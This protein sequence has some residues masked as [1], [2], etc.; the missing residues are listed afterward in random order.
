MYI[1]SACIFIPRLKSG[2]T[3]AIFFR[4]YSSAERQ[5]TNISDRFCNTVNNVVDLIHTDIFK[6]S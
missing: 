4:E 6:I 5:V 2:T 1:V 3:F